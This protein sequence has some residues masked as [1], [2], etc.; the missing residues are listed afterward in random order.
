MRKPKIVFIDSGVATDNQMLKNETIEEIEIPNECAGE[1][2]QSGHGTAI[3]GIL[4]RVR[5][6]FDIISIK[7]PG[8]QNGVNGSIL[9]DA[10]EYIEDHIEVKLINLSLGSTILDEKEKV[11]TVCDRMASKG[12]IIVAAFDNGGAISFPAAFKSVI[13]VISSSVCTCVEDYEIFD[14]DVV[15]I[16]GKGGIQK[17]LWNSPPVMLLGG[18]S[19]ACANISVLVAKMILEGCRNKEE[20]LAKLKQK[21]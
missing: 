20:V 16:A 10:L 19:F 21:H 3:Y 6:N 15:N 4:R 1:S 17:V 5:E 11:K 9:Y 8:I 12:I 13:G 7:I 14:D 2:F 18:N